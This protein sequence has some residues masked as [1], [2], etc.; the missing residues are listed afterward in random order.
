MVWNLM[1]NPQYQNV[2]ATSY[3]TIYLT[4]RKL[5]RET[6][7]MS[8]DWLPS[9]PHTQTGIY[10]T[11]TPE[12]LIISSQNNGLW[13]SRTMVVALINL[14]AQVKVKNIHFNPSYHF[15]WYRCLEFASDVLLYQSSPTKKKNMFQI[16][17][18]TRVWFRLI[19]SWPMLP[20]VVTITALCQ[21]TSVTSYAYVEIR[22]TTRRAQTISRCHSRTQK[23][24]LNRFGRI[25]TFIGNQPYRRYGVDYEEQNHTICLASQ[26]TTYTVGP[27]IFPQRCL[28]EHARTASQHIF[29]IQSMNIIAIRVG[30]KLRFH[31]RSKVKPI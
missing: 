9:L 16:A 31:E 17:S 7:W 8:F 25:Y 23:Y 24:T 12:T 18:D 11:K 27:P 19:A 4:S 28:T 2:T 13:L 30:Y 5:Y 6:V 22:R 26:P 14:A 1:S 3:L 20:V 10:Q 21:D 15:Q 29:K